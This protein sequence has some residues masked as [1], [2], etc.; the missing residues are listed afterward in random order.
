MNNNIK[1]KKS[2]EEAIAITKN[3]IKEY[4]RFI[5]ICQEKVAKQYYEENIWPLIEEASKKGLMEIEF[6]IPEKIEHNFLYFPEVEEFPF[7]E[8]KRKELFL[9]SIL[10][11]VKEK[12]DVFHGFIISWHFSTDLDSDIRRIGF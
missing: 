5:K 4:E 3:A 12:F 6:H 1:N 8:N 7:D 10:R 2:N 9:V 11:Y